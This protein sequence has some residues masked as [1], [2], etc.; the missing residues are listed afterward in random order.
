MA[1]NGL[2]GA[3]GEGALRAAA[4]LH[5]HTGVLEER[6]AQAIISRKHLKGDASERNDRKDAQGGQAKD[7]AAIWDR[8]NVRWWRAD[9]CREAV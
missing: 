3:R 2:Q 4:G 8:T 5:W 9:W 7:L 6:G 1:A